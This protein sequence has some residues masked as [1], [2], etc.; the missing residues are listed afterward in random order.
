[1]QQ[2]PSF[3]ELVHIT[4]SAVGEPVVFAVILVPVAECRYLC[5]ITARTTKIEEITARLRNAGVVFTK[6]TPKPPLQRVHGFMVANSPIHAVGQNGVMFGD[7]YQLDAARYWYRL[8]P[9]DAPA[10]VVHNAPSRNDTQSKVMVRGAF[11][12]AVW[13]AFGS[14]VRTNL[15]CNYVAVRDDRIEVTH[16]KTSPI[17]YDQIVSQF[18][19]LR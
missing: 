7:M 6:D 13:Q 14:A 18:P 2:Q 19:P 15:P 4:V 17:T 10:L 3:A 11:D 8:R 9:Y 12:R 1:M 16:D 5:S